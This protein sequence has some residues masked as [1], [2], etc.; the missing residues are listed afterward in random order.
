M[1]SRRTLQEPAAAP[2]AAGAARPEAIAGVLVRPAWIFTPQGRLVTGGVATVTG[3][4]EAWNASVAK[5]D[6][7]GLVASLYFSEGLREVRIQLDDGRCARARIIGTTFMP[8][9]E[10]VCDLAGLEPLA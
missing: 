2:Q 3:T 6:R 1:Q 5:L 10:R 8:A 9:A 7:P 4:A